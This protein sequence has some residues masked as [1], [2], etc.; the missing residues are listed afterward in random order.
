[1]STERDKMLAGELYAPLDGELV[2]A[3]RNAGLGSRPPQRRHRE[4]Q[5]DERRRILQAAARRRR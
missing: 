3:R 1:M 5:T 4:S 2:L